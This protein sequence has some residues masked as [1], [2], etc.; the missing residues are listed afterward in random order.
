M[1]YSKADLEN[2]K[3]IVELAK[4]D[5]ESFGILYESNYDQIFAFVL[6]RTASIQVAQDITSETFLKA[7][8]N[9][10]NFKWQNVPFSAWLYRIAINE[11]SLWQRNRSYKAISLDGLRDKG[12]E[13][14]S[15]AD[16][17]EELIKAQQSVER[18]GQYILVQKELELIPA[19]YREVIALRFFEGKQLLEIAQILGKPEGTVKS[20]LHRGLE[21]LK[22]IVSSGQSTATFDPNKHYGKRRAD[23]DA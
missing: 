22:K 17:E 2:E 13:P 18:H 19:K 4:S 16:M 12:F 7:L 6:R 15:E 21:K 9:I 1:N 3:K 8:K 23:V 5:P 14:A 10:H 11:I 20:L